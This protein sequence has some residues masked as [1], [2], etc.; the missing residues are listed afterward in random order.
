MIFVPEARS[1]LLYIFYRMPVCNTHSHCVSFTHRNLIDFWCFHSFLFVHASCQ[2]HTSHFEKWQ[3]KWFSRHNYDVSVYNI[4]FT[5]PVYI[6]FHVFPLEISFLFVERTSF[7]LLQQTMWQTH[8][9]QK[10]I[11][12]VEKL[13]F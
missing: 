8:Y 5:L 9:V 4:F 13:H 2:W 3:H 12:I 11:F 7:H 10:M 6:S 1:N